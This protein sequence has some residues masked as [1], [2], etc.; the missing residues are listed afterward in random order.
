MSKNIVLG[1]GCFWC[2]ES[3][4][5][6]LDGVEDVVSGYAGGSTANPS[7]HEVCTGETGHAEVVKISYD[8]S[9]VG[10]EDILDV[11]FVIH[12]P[13]TKNREGPDIGSQYRSII[14]Y[15][16]DRQE[17]IANQKIQNLED[18]GSYDN[19]VTELVDL[20]KFYVA[21]SKHQDF[22][23][24]NPN[25]AYCRFHIPEKIDKVEKLNDEI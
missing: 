13:E 7:Y 12:N 9:V 6:H 4:F 21:E 23:E 22:Y 14:L 10:L 18:N 2:L 25:S 8:G 3:A 11:F 16:N 1:G 20:D 24:R 5:K 17:E 19:I 15:D